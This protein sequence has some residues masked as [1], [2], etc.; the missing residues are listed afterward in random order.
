MARRF[1]T[2]NRAVRAS[3]LNPIEKS[4][5]PETHPLRLRGQVVQLQLLAKFE[6]LGDRLVA[7]EVGGLEVIQQTASLANHH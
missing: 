5:E 4:E 7:A 1:K 2:A 6:F 3:Q